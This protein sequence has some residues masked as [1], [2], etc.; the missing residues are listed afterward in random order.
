MA[1]EW[2]TQSGLLGSPL[3]IEGLPDKIVIRAA[4][5]VMLA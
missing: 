5:G 4:H 1:G 2:L 3:E